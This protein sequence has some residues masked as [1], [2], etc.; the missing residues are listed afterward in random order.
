MTFRLTL[1]FAE[2]ETS[3]GQI[4]ITSFPNRPLYVS[5]LRG[6]VI[7]ASRIPHHHT[8]DLFRHPSEEESIFAQVSVACSFV[9][10]GER[11]A[12]PAERPSEHEGALREDD[13]S[14]AP[15]RHDED[16]INYMEALFPTRSIIT[17]G[18][19]GSKVRSKSHAEVHR[20]ADGTRCWRI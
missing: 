7:S 6:V 10:L 15:A 13:N 18:I 5:I 14:G 20:R 11:N 1:Y 2:S 19:F 12:V 17:D 3:L 16:V 4:R 8:S 9:L